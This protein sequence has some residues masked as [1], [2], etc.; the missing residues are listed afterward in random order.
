M[1]ALSIR[2]TY[3]LYHNPIRDIWAE[4]E[5]LDKFEQVTVEIE[6]RE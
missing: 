4:P 5:G 6:Y 1:R 2:Q 3:F